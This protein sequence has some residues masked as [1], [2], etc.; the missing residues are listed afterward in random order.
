M[1]VISVMDIAVLTFDGFNEIDSFVFFSI[2][3]RL[4]AE[5]RNVRITSAHDVLITVVTCFEG[6]ECQGIA[7]GSGL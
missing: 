1:R 7:S 4:K 5:G 2:L 6:I 3:N